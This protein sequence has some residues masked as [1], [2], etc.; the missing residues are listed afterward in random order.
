M[1][2]RADVGPEK[3]YDVIGAHQ[4]FVLIKE[5]LRDTH[6]LLDIGCGS[7]RGGRLFIPYLK[8]GNYFGIEPNQELLAE[9]IERE[10][11]RCIFGVKAP[12]FHHNAICDATVFEEAFDFVLAQ[13][14]FSHAPQLLIHWCFESVKKTLKPG[15]KFLFTY[16]SG[17][18]NYGG[19]SWTRQPCAYYTG[20]WM[21]KTVEER[22]FVLKK[23]PYHHPSE[24]TW[25]VATHA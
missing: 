6:K 4:F 14:I 11:G 10:L 20:S 8:K 2:Y 18:R 17:A 5:G 1:N 22:G 16:F 7:L 25:M 21:K 9:G 24:Q 15:G 23:L 19:D 3:K 12:R 13:S